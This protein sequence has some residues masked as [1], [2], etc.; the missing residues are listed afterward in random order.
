MK[1]SM[2]NLF[3]DIGAQRVN[4]DKERFIGP[5]TLIVCW[6]FNEPCP[7]LAMRSVELGMKEESRDLVAS[8]AHLCFQ[9][10]SLKQFG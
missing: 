5:K 9:C 7:A 4:K 3:V 1:I 8:A 10:S 6:A 2:E